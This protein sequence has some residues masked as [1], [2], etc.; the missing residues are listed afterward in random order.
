MFK[1]LLFVLAMLF[2]LSLLSLHSVS[3]AA[4]PRRI[5]I[6]VNAPSVPRD[7]FADLS[8]G[9]DYPGTLIR[10]DSLAQLQT[11]K[12]E[13]GFRY[14]RFHGIFHDVLQTYTEHDGKPVYDWSKIDIL[15][16]RLLRMGI[17]PFVELG[18]TPHAMR[19]SEKTIF[20]WKGNISHPDPVKWTALVDAFVRHLEVRYGKEEVQSWYFEVW[21]EPNLAIFWEGADQAAYFDLY[22][23]TARAIKAIDPQLRV[24]GPATAGAAWVPEFLAFTQKTGAPV[25]FITTHTYGVDGGFIDEHGVSD[26]KLSTSPH[27]IVADVHKVRAQIKATARPEL[28]LFFTEWSSSYTPRD[29]VHDSYVSAA[30]LLSKLKSSEG[31]LQGM[32]YWTYTDLFE[33]PGPPTAPFEGGFGLLNPQ[34]IRKPAFFAYKYLHQLGDEILTIQDRQDA[35]SYVSRSGKTLQVLAWDYHQPVQDKSNRAFYTKVLPSVETAPL[36]LQ[37]TGLEPGKYTAQIYR[38]GYLANDAHTAY[39]EMG[40][41][42]SLSAGQLQTLQNLT[43]D[44]PELRKLQ[45]SSSG[46]VYIKVTMRENDVILLKLT[47]AQR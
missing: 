37:L 18:F 43:V 8:I 6:D 21:N 45:V 42:K 26:T 1:P 35:Q 14:L 34:G 46:K 15:Y 29:P 30:Y 10:E 7:H 31:Q 33:E 39:L 9:S 44:K 12:D 28:P 11:I 25:D 27:A 23:R 2:F 5:S 20:Y 19:S 17:K 36:E 38:T 4:A 24:G 32:S 41:P 40:S 47:A 3:H 16:D 13:L 22:E